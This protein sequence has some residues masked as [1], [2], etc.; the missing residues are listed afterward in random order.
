MYQNRDIV[1]FENLYLTMV[2]F[3]LLKC[4]YLSYSPA[5]FGNKSRPNMLN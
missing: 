4:S 5:Q 2:R 1:D 3:I